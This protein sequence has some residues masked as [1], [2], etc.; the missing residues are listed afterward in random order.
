MMQNEGAMA[1][2]ERQSKHG[3]RVHAAPLP[4]PGNGRPAHE[5]I[6]GATILTVN[7]CGVAVAG[8]SPRD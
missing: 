5:R 4:G 7:V 3:V 2:H 6:G 8:V 1:N